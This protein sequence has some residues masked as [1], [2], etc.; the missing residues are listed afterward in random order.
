MEQFPPMITRKQLR[1]LLKGMRIRERRG[2]RMGVVLA[3]GEQVS[4][5]R[6]D[7][8]YQPPA[9]EYVSNQHIYPQRKEP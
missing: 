6:W 4:Q 8:E 1:T 5:V 3:V 9:D 2:G 7:P